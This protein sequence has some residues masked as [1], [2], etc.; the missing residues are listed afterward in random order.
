M[1]DPVQVTKTLVDF[2]EQNNKLQI[3]GAGASKAKRSRPSR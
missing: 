3:D 1:S 2:A